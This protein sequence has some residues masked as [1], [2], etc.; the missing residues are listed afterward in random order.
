[1]SFSAPP[2]P[3]LPTLP[4]APAA[5]VGLTQNSPQGQKPTAKPSQPTFLGA[6]LFANQSNTGQKSLI[7]Q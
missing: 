6:G 1:M 5:P 7:G 4:A 2:A 3:A